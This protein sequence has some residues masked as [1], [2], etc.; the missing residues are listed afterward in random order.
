MAG[1]IEGEGD[2]VAVGH[3]VCGA[4]GAAG[5]AEEDAGVGVHGGAVFGNGGVEFPHHDCF[6]VVEKV[7]ADAGDVFG[8][9]D[10]EGG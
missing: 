3:D 8:D 2:L 10:G 9:G 1:G 6:G 5:G 4:V 7:V